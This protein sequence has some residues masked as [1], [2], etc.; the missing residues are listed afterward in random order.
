M[1]NQLALL[2]QRVKTRL[3]AVKDPVS[4][5][6][7]VSSGRILGLEARADGKVCFTIEAPSEAAARYV[8]VRDAAD[9]AVRELEG[10]A[11][12]PAVLT[13]DATAVSANRR[14]L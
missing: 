12:V 2:E 14:W 4:G 3:E 13:A 5:K 7:L 8:A 6:G 1:N 9:A 11:E 10:V